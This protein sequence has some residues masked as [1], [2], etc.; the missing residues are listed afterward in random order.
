[1]LIEG[2]KVRE[3]DDEEDEEEVCKICWFEFE[4]ELV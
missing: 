2:E 3:D 4:L 1:M